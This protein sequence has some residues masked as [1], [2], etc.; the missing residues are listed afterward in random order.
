VGHSACKTQKIPVLVFIVLRMVIIS[1]MT[2]NVSSVT[3]NPTIPYL[4]MVA[5]SGENGYLNGC[6]CV[7]IIYLIVS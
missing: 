3:L 1:G 5:A 6:V 2:Y 7:H 4:R